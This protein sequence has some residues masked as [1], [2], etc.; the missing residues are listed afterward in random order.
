METIISAFLLVFLAEMGDKTQFLALIFAT[1]YKVH[2]V[3]LGIFLG[4]FVNHG[5]AVIL[6][7]FLSSFINLD[8]LKVIAGIMFLIF[9]LESFILKIQDDEDDD[10]K[11]KFGAIIT[12]ATCF[13]I[14]ELGD[15]TQITSMSVVFTGKNPMLTL[16]GTTLGMV[17]VSL[18]GILIGRII[19]GKIPKDLMKKV[20][21]L[22]FIIFG[23]DA[24]NKAVPVKYLTKINIGLFYITIATIIICIYI[25][26]LKLKKKIDD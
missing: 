10:I 25:R 14:G 4:V 18:F 22:C 16:I 12:V 8:I 24:L 17:C 1:K 3:I 9:G 2:Q 11:Y 15:K 26:N 6:A 13:F 21:G 20:S 5:I 23:I 19:K 7:K